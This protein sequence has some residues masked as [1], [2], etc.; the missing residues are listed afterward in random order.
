MERERCIILIQK[1]ANKNDYDAKYN[2]KTITSKYYDIKDAL[3]DFAANRLSSAT[4]P[5][6]EFIDE[7]QSYFIVYV[8]ILVDSK[9]ASADVE[10]DI[11]LEYYDRIFVCN[12]EDPGSEFAYYYYKDKLDRPAS[13]GTVYF[14][15]V[16]AKGSGLEVVAG[17][18]H[19]DDFAAARTI[20]IYCTDVDGDNIQNISRIETLDDNFMEFP[21]LKVN[22]DDTAMTAQSVGQVNPIQIRYPMKL[23]VTANSIDSNKGYELRM[24]CKIYGPPNVTV[25][26]G[27]TGVAFDASI[28][29][30]YEVVF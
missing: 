5:V 6:N 4:I 2:P 29:D 15:F 13:A 18:V 8:D 9:S 20:N 21:T 26:T 12:R 1:F 24:L 19:G 27:D 23:R 28:G 3:P 22:D 14:E 30:A 25:N 10:F 11:V 16:P 7:T 17:R